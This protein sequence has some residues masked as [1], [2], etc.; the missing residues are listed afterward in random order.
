MSGNPRGGT[1]DGRPPHPATVAQGKALPPHAA[2]VAQG[3]GRPPH[4]ATVAQGKGRPPHPA[5]VAQRRVLQRM[6]MDVEEEEDV[7][8]AN[9]QEVEQVAEEVENDGYYQPKRTTGLSTKEN[10][11]EIEKGLW[12]AAFEYSKKLKNSDLLDDLDHTAGWLNGKLNVAYKDEFPQHG[13]CVAVTIVYPFKDDPRL[14]VGCNGPNPHLAMP[15]ITRALHELAGTQNF[16]QGLKTKTARAWWQK[17][18]RPYI[19][20][21]GWMRYTHAELRLLQ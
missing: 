16:L 6:N 19:L 8:C 9:E 12:H 13:K 15:E 3:K 21:P 1:V 14:L 5:T 20:A 2:T 18:R 4:P 7:F 10:F 17:E 11:E